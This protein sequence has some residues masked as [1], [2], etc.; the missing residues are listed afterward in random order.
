MDSTGE[1]TLI[2]INLGIVGNRK[3]IRASDIERLCPSV[4]SSRP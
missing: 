2:A 1:A 4:D 3:I